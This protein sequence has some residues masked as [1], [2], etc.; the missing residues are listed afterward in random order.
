MRRL[1][2]TVDSGRVVPA[3]T[4]TRPRPVWETLKSGAKRHSGG[5]WFAAP[6]QSGWYFY[7]RTFDNNLGPFKTFE[8]GLEVWRED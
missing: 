2:R 8:E 3:K 5:K 6:Y 7:T 1:R 4:K